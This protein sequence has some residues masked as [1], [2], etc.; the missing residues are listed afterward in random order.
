MAQDKLNFLSNFGNSA[1]KS[2]ISTKKKVKRRQPVGSDEEDMF[3]GFSEDDET[4]IS[5]KKLKIG[6]S[7]FLD[8]GSTS[9][10]MMLALYFLT[11][12]DDSQDACCTFESIQEMIEVLK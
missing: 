11:L 2:T 3:G 9:W 5:V 7:D 10:S 12:H 8:I 6:E 1:E 4:K